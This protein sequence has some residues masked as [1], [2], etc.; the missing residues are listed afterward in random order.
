MDVITDRDVRDM[1]ALTLGDE[2]E[3]FDVPAIAADLIAQFG[4]SEDYPDE[5]YWTA[6]RNHEKPEPVDPR[7]AFQR[8]MSAALTAPREAGA[9]A[10][11]ADETVTVTVHGA[12]R[13]N[14]SWP[15]PTARVTL[16]TPD[17]AQRT[18]DGE[19]IGSWDELW[20][21]VHEESEAW[22]SDTEALLTQ[23]RGAQDALDRAQQA[24]TQARARRDTLIREAAAAG[25]SAYR[26]AQRLR[27]SQPT[28]GRVLR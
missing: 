1:V 22:T 11:W 9:P 27:V 26:I 13:V 10:V 14:T 15:S 25:I 18:I 20:A 6:V 8:E 28:V 3:R 16:S 19:D 17:G 24:V 23:A 21:L 2:V 12:S 7:E 5:E 4:L